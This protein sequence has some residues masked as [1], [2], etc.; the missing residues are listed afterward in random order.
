VVEPRPTLVERP[1]VVPRV[2]VEPDEQAGTPVVQ[3]NGVP[4]VLVAVVGRRPG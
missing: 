1:T 4:T 2:V 3:E